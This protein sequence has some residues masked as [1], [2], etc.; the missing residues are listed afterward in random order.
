[1]GAACDEGR[2]GAAEG[3]EEQEDRSWGMGGHALGGGGVDSGELG[4][5]G[6]RLEK[7]KI[8]RREE[9]VEAEE[10]RFRVPDLPHEDKGGELDIEAILSSSRE[11]EDEDAVGFTDITDI[12]LLD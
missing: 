8:R 11:E 9:A 6:E 7:D 5:L 10:K 12:L 1:V 4:E 3:E 2:S